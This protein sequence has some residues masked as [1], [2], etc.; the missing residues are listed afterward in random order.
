GGGRFERANFRALPELSPPALSQA[1]RKCMR[2][3][4]KFAAVLSTLMVFNTPLSWGQ[5]PPPP[6]V[7]NPQAPVLGMPMPLGVQRGSSI[8]LNL[9]G[10]SLAGPAGLWTSFAAKV[11]VP[12][13]NKK[14]TDNP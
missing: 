5:K 8:E 10:T 2:R 11:T 7:P 3:L 13:D 12:T 1:V 14:P 9:T 4:S 6:I